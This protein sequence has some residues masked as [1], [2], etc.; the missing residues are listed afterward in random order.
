MKTKTM[1][2]KNDDLN[3]FMK[4]LAAAFVVFAIYTIINDPAGFIEGILDALNI[5]NFNQNN[6]SYLKTL[7]MKRKVNNYLNW[8][9]ALIVVLL[10]LEWESTKQAIKDLWNNN[11]NPPIEKI[12][13]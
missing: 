11:Y 10:I 2:T 3:R 7:P 12:K 5:S 13:Q 6:F 9:L 8:I 4:I 1:K